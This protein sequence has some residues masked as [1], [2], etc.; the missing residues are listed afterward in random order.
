MAFDFKKIEEKVLAFWES[1]RIFERSMEL[2]AKGRKKFVFFEGPPTANGHPHMGHFEGRL[3][4]DLFNRYKTMRGYYVLRK[5]GWD[6]HGLPVELQVEKEL[7]FKSKKDIEAYGIAQFNRKCRE[8]VWAYINEWEEMT[9]RMGF[10]VDMA[11]PYI[12]Y[13]TPYVE[14][15]WAIL[16][17]IWDKK[18][19]YLAHKVVPFCTR[20]GTPLSSHE[21]AQGYK[22]IIENSVYLK[23]KLKPGQKIG[24][25]ITND[26]TY[27]LS[28]TTT[29]W[30]LPGNV[31]LAVGKDMR[32]VLGNF[33]KENYIL[34]KDLINKIFPLPTAS[35]LEG[36]K[37]K[38]KTIL[39]PIKDL[40]GIDLTG[41]EY[42][43][44]FDIPSLK[45][46]TSYK[47]YAADFVTTDEGTGVVH[48]AVMYGEDDY[49][50]GTREDLPKIHT[51]DEQGKFIGVSK[52]LNGKYVKSKETEKTILEYLKSRENLFASEP[53]EHD[54]PYCW[55]CDTPLLYYA[56]TSWFIRMTALKDQ[57]LAN[58]A[59]VN[60]IP[61]HIKEGRFGQWLRE[62]KDWAIS[63]ERY[64]GTPLPIWK[65]VRCEAH[66][67]IGS[68]AELRAH[69]IP[70]GNTYYILRHGVTTRNEH[71]KMLMSFQLDKDIYH[72]TDEGLAQV[73]NS[74]EKFKSIEHFDS[75]YASPFIRTQETADIASRLFKIKVQT[76]DRLREIEHL[77]VC[78]GQS[79]ATCNER[80]KPTAF[81]R[82]DAGESWNDVRMRLSEFMEEIES[83]HKG[84]KILIVSHGDPLWLLGY[85]G[86]GMTA[87]EILSLERSGKG[88]Y[89]EFGTIRKI[90]WEPIPRNELGELDLHRPFVDN[91]AFRCDA[92]GAAMKRIT[93]LADVWFDSGCMPFAQW[94]WPF[95]NAKIFKSQFPADFIV[96]G[97]DQTRGWFYTLLAVS[98]LLEKGTPYKNVMSLGHVLDEKGQ[99]LSKSKGNYVSPHEIMNSYSV[100]ATRWYFYTVNSP[101]EPK[102]FSPRDVEE[103][104]KG[105][106]ATLQNCM[107]F[108]EL[109]KENITEQETAKNE[110]AYGLL[111]KWILSRLSSTTRTVT[112]NLDAY[113]PMAAARTLERFVVDDLSNW[114]LRRSR[115]RTGSLPILRQLLLEVAKLCAPFMPFTAEDIF[116]RLDGRAL[117]DVESIHLADW[118]SLD[119]K[120]ISS[121][122]ESIMMTV[123]EIVTRGLATRKEKQIKVRQPLASIMIEGGK[124]DPDLEE[125]IRD[126]LNVKAVQYRKIGELELDTLLT[127]ELLA[128]GFVR[129]FMRQVQDMRK[130]IGY[131]FYDKAYCQWH[132][133]DEELARAIMSWK[134]TI[135]KDTVLSEL[136]NRAHAKKHYDAEKELD[137]APGK[138]LWLG[139]HK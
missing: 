99:K 61:E 90:A 63:R 13:E 131:K 121:K 6:T 47:V 39:I 7:G 119:K 84:K 15:L 136:V 32:Y 120:R 91:V 16:K 48:T 33:G 86:K 18:F 58:N 98:T 66:S 81:E 89:P 100:D 26:K 38:P 123:Q 77:I 8:N 118:P 35:K 9:K 30:T 53:Y 17:Q 67:A 113:D 107:R 55:R 57:L 112:E 71:E 51:V 28:W 45:S 62:G 73:T 102:L 130:E 52:E 137:I 29:P 4:K 80:H 69:A 64:W 46:A 50:L 36:Q 23:F 42:E 70:S 97:V 106:L 20:C 75:I 65:C 14:S 111:D 95:E 101:G 12:T 11:H 78:E 60:W 79:L 25:F 116:I 37:I 124:L 24:N 31:A 129:E 139:I 109:Y 126:E 133:D 114:W 82:N 21:V 110:K 72:M 19:L 125:L 41:L 27:I 68:I 22:K 96:E 103:R 88:W 34:A 135:K 43:P 74:L 40:A 132:T 128:E 105:F 3:F 87:E 10:W 108:F 104:L 56:K 117:T 115:K 93:D 44:L 5:A 49:E 1:Q 122:L 85:M 94:H 54:Y 134:D 127:K 83:T 59:Q 92:C 76:N 2:R 138:R